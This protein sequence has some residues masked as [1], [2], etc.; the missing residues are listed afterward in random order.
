GYAASNVLSKHYFEDVTEFAIADGYQ[1]KMIYLSYDGYGNYKVLFRTSTF[2]G[3]IVMD[4]AFW[5]DYEYVAFN[6]SSI[7]SSDLSG[8]LDTLPGQFSFTR[9]AMTFTSGY[10]NSGATEI[11]TGDTTFIKQYAASNPIPRTFI[12]AGT[13]ITIEAG[14]KVKVIFLSYSSETGYKVEFRTGDNTG[15]LLLTD[16]MYKEYQYI[17]F[18][19]SQTTANID[20]SGN[21]DTMEAK[22]VFSMFDEAIVDHV[23]AALSFTTGYYEDNKTAITTGDTAFIKGFAAS[24]V[25]S[26]DYFAG[27]ASVEVA[28]GYQVRVV[29]LAYDHNTYTVVYRTANLTGTIIMDAAFWANY[30]YVA[31]TISSV[32]SSDLSGVLET[33]PALLTFVDEV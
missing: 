33:L 2:T 23:D 3:T 31:F 26:K 9:T 24:N 1:V 7:P 6:I 29:F 20:E 15:E 11:T 27:K 12:P 8:V 18:N 30:E 14:Y 16:A 28:A 19:I 22:M 32:P 25:L 4:A 21:L 17:A 13:I 10:W 5:G